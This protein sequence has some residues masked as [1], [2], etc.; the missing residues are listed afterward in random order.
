MGSED[1]AFFS[2][3]VPACYVLLGLANVARGLNAPHHSP[4][5]DFDE[6]VLSLGVAVF[7]QALARYL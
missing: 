1:F 7:A 4:H 5:F 2:Q 6:D 3:R